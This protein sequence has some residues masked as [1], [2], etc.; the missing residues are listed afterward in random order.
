MSLTRERRNYSPALIRLN[1]RSDRDIHSRNADESSR[2][3]CNNAKPRL[4]PLASPAIGAIPVVV[5]IVKP[6]E[7][8][9]ARFV[10]S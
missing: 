8:G 1:N 10:S 9:T 3:N 7:P 5:L 2:N 4:K 6:E